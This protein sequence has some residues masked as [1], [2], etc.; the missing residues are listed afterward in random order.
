VSLKGESASHGK[1]VS[2]LFFFKRGK[3]E[4]ISNEG[5]GKKKPFVKLL[6]EKS[7]LYEKK[8]IHA[9]P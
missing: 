1:K 4:W 5:G 8:G 3:K 7:S 6:R 9:L 2:S